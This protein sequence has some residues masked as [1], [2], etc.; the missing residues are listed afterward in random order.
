M[1]YIQGEGRNQGILSRAACS[2]HA[3]SK[4]Y[5]RITGNMVL[6]GFLFENIKLIIFGP[7]M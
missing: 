5:V 1:G 6:T 3:H 2:G 4:F 7:Y